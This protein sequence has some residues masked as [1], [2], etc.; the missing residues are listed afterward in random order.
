MI[1]V[2]IGGTG[3]L[4]KSLKKLELDIEL[5]RI[6]P[7]IIINA[8]AIKSEKVIE[9]KEKSININIIGASNIAKYCIKN[10]IKLVYISGNNRF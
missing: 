6:K 3:M 10:N 2:I 9:E 7:N 4:G 5:N 8:A 1:K